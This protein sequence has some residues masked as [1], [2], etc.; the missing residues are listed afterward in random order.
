MNNNGI[1]APEVFGIGCSMWQRI[2]KVR[3]WQWLYQKTSPLLQVFLP[4]ML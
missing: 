2:I 1:T 3:I 4:Q